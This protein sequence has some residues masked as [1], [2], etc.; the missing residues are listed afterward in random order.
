MSGGMT[1]S[2]EISRRQFFGGVAAA[3]AT[4]ALAPE[5]L[6]AAET[7]TKLN[8][9]LVGCGGRGSWIANLFQRHGGCNLVAVA[10]YFEDRV[11]SVGDKFQIP[12]ER[13]FTGISGYKRL[14]DQKLDAVAIQSPAYFHPEHAAA[15]VDA[16]KHVYLAK[17]VAVDVPGCLTIAKAGRRATEK[18]LI[19]LVDF[20]T[21]A[22]THYQ[23]AI[24]LVHNGLIG[25]IASGEA[26]YLCGPTFTGIAAALQKNPTDPE[27]RLRA[28]SLSRELS[29]DIITEQNIHALDV[30][31]WILGAD[32][33]KAAGAGGEIRGL[34][35]T[36]WDHFSVTYWFPKN[37]LLTFSSKQYGYGWDD[38]CCRMYGDKGV[39]DTH[40]FGS[41]KVKG[42]EDGYSA[43][44]LADLYTEGAINNIA[45]FAEQIMRGDASNRTVNESVRSNLTTILGRTAAYK[46]SEV[47]WANM[48]KA[49]ECFS[50]D[51]KGLKA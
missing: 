41:I 45:T 30:A 42:V 24:Q 26:T 33:I 14:L 6:R 19:F 18:G 4:V 22:N 27:T 16:G 11:N 10:D 48:M 12:P 7:Q 40:Y 13:R 35:G 43:G 28:W 49:N 8:W 23:K 47:T 50:Y 25:Q 36:C 38:I 29:G 20:Q 2:S 3:T 39:I 17:P 1:A 46:N 34:G 32:P 31:C 5:P 9:G 15:A 21:R 37:I 44:P 51:L